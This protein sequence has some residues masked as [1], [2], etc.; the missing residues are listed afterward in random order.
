MTASLLLLFSAFQLPSACPG[1]V[2]CLLQL[3]VDGSVKITKL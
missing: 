2:N 3:G 1:C